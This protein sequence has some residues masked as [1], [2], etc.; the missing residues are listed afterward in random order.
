MDLK[1]CKRSLIAYKGHV[2]RALNNCTTLLDQ[3]E[4]DV[5][6]YKNVIKHMEI[7][8]AQYDECYA[9]VEEQL[10]ALDETDDD[11]TKL[12]DEYYRLQSNYQKNITKLRTTVT[13]STQGTPNPPQSNSKEVSSRPKLP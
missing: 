4:V 13:A 6:E 9:K 7:K 11:I 2:T 1:K 8:W 5:V 3:E 12:Q 10:L